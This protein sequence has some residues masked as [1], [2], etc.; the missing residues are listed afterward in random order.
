MREGL[1][2]VE[3]VACPL[4]DGKIDEFSTGQLRG[5]PPCLLEGGEHLPRPGDFVGVGVERSMDFRQ[6]GGVDRGFTEESE[7]ATGRGFPA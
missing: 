7:G 1:G 4:R 5:C 6:L 3:D 2:R